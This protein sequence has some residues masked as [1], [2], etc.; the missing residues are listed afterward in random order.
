MGIIEDDYETVTVA[1]P[2]PFAEVL[3]KHAADDGV[4]LQTECEMML[5]VGAAKSILIGSVEPK[6]TVG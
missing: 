2:K 5:S 3:R 1:I 6:I 4:T